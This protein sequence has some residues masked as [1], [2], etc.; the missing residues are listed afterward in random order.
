M[1]TL[2]GFSH[3]WVG[4]K[5]GS[6]TGHVW[7]HLEGEAV[8]AFGALNLPPQKF[9]VLTGSSEFEQGNRGGLFHTHMYCLS[10]HRES[11]GTG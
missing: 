10:Y 1:K 5:R 8:G 6:C 3:I 11:P 9:P 7:K 2:S 4:D